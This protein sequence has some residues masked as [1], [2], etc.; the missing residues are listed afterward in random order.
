MAIELAAA[1]IKVLSVDEIA[2]RL[3]DRFSLL[4]AGSRTAIPRHQ[5]LRATIDWSY[6]LLTEPER[7]LLRRLA[8]FAGG[9]TLEAAEA[10]CSQGMKRNDI[11]DLIGRLV[12][13]S[14][15]IVEADSEISGTRYHLLET[16]RQY[17]FEKLA[18]IGGEERVIRNQHLEFFTKLAEDAEP[19]TFGEEAAIWFRRLDKELD[20]LRTAIDWSIERENAIGAMRLVGALNDFFLSHG[21]LSEWKERLG[22]VLSLPGGSERTLA[23]AKVLN[24]IGYLYWA[25]IDPG[26]K[27]TELEEALAI[28]RE[29]GDKSIIAIALRNLGLFEN[30][31]G[32]PIRA[33]SYLEQSLKICREL[34]LIGRWHLSL[35]L[36]FLGD[37]TLIQGELDKARQLYEGSVFILREGKDRSFLAYSVRRLGQLACH[38]GD[39]EVALGHCLESLRLNLEF[40]DPLGIIASLAAFAGVNLARGK[41]KFAAELFGNIQALLGA[42][43]L[44]L[45]QIDQTEYEQNVTLLQARLDQDSLE[46]AWAKGALKTMDQAVEFALK[47]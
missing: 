20:N 17:A 27:H 28:G 29:L 13:K 31:R 11:L 9:F 4:T 26:D 1:R 7:V 10:V 2:A 47:M 43:S 12:D 40:G 14:L 18:E 21:P 30:L 41:T 44:R 37:V 16:I 35:T 22:R 19:N 15:V 36:I 23:R 32:D 5:T 33:R 6:D 42:R 45:L 34:G 46:E 38:R 39:Y 8:V 3:D 25:E 24:G